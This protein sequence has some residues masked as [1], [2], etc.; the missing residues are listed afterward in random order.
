MSQGNAYSI[1][2]KKYQVF[3]TA[4][5]TNLPEQFEAGQS[6]VIMTIPKNGANTVLLKNIDLANDENAQG[7]NGEYYVSKWGED[8]TGV[9]TGNTT[10]INEN[11]N[12]NF[13]L[14]YYPNPTSNGKFTVNVSSSSDQL[15]HLKVYDVVGVCVF[16]SKLD[17]NANIPYLKEVNLDKLSKGTYLID[18]SNNKLK[19]SGKVVIF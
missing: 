11:L 8:M 18:V 2:G 9:I 1:G 19:Y 10:F 7:L 12:D 14:S 4:D 3:A 17:V 5:P 16:D 13:I 15:L 6:V